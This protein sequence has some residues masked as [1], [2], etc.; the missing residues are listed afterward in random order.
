MGIFFLMILESMIFPVPSEAVMP[1]AGFL[2]FS[3][4]M[5]FWPIVLAGTAGSIAGSLASYA[6]GFYGGR[7]FILRYGNYFFL[8]EKHLLMTELF[9]NRFGNKAIFISRFIPV[10]R[11]LISIPAGIGEMPLMRFT[12]YTTIGASMWNSFLAY[13]GYVLGS[14]WGE[15]KKYSESVDIFIA[16]GIIAYCGYWLYRQY[17]RSRSQPDQPKER[18]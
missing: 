1:F 3:G 4:G 15:I 8:N 2:W 9:F 16:L 11:H 5:S 6:I 7:A 13:V 10:V 18:N 14:N 12:L 17:R